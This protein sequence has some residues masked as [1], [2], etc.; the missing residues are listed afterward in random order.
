[1]EMDKTLVVLLLA[2]VLLIVGVALFRVT[3]SSINTQTTIQSVVNESG[4]NAAA[5]INNTD[6]STTHVFTIGHAPGSASAKSIAIVGFVL[7]N[8][9]GSAATNNTD[10]IVNTTYGTYTLKDTAFWTKQ[11]VVSNATTVDYQY[12]SSDY[13]TQ[14]A[15]RNIMGLILIFIAL[16]LL[17]YVASPMIKNFRDTSNKFNGFSKQGGYN[18][19]G[20]FKR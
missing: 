6:V 1:M 11:T 17:L 7:K 16:S 3:A 10:Y 15:S 20:S 14:P 13:I 8:S 18:M 4:S 19:T 9:T 5:V 2:F 12:Y